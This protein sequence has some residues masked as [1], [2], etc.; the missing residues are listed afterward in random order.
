MQDLQRYEIQTALEQ[1][2]TWNNIAAAAWHAYQTQ[3]AGCLLVHEFPPKEVEYV[4]R[5]EGVPFLKTNG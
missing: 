1:P 3:G 2:L 5:A 4:S